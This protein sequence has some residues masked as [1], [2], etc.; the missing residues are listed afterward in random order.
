LTDS[1]KIGSGALISA[2]NMLYYYNQKGELKLLSFSEGKMTEIS[3]F[4]IQK[5][6]KEHF[7]HPVIHNG[8]LY[9][10]HGNVLMGF[11]IKKKEEV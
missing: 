4:K 7:S 11:D 1:L 10:R 2:D 6:S 8:V 9:L 5:G 3:S